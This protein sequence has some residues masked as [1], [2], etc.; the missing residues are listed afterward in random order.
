METTTA[1]KLIARRNHQTLYEVAL[2]APD[3]RR[4][5]V[6][7][8]QRSGRMLRQ[9]V[10]KRAT[11]LVTT[12]GDETT[13]IVRV[14]KDAMTLSGGWAVRFTGRTEREAIISGELPAIAAA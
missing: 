12:I 1:R 13:E 8:A 10:T 3:G 6:C 5:L 4:F 2:V 11:R 7:Y 14:T 9:G